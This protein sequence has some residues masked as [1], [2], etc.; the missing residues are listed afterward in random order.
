MKKLF[1]T[2]SLISV[3]TL[4]AFAFNKQ[5]ILL[6]NKSSLPYNAYTVADLNAEN[7]KLSKSKNF[8]IK[9][10]IE[11][12][13]NKTAFY[14]LQ[15]ELIATTHKGTIEEMPTPALKKIGNGYKGY[16]IEEVIVY[17]G[18]VPESDYL[19]TKDDTEK[20]YFVHLVSE[21]ESIILRVTTSGTVSFFKKL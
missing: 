15:K 16:I 2:T 6:S 13:L 20:M 18:K 5:H 17:E 4:A 1:L 10:F 19:S 11:E 8:F 7:A 9:N 12:G 21:K 14:N 3:L